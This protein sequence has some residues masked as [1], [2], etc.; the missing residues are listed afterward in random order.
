MSKTFSNSITIARVADGSSADS[1]I[2]ETS[3]DEILKFDTINEANEDVISFSPENF[4]IRVYNINNENPI[5]NFNWALYYLNG[6]QEYEFIAEKTNLNGFDEAI[7][8]E[9]VSNYNTLYIKCLQFYEVV[10]NNSN[11]S[12]LKS[13]IKDGNAFFKFIYIVN[14]KAEAIKYFSI[15]NGVSSDMA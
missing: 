3:Y 8:Y 10:E 6:N 9:P 7:S 5:L 2:I 11:F 12:Y 4:K 1:I 13:I 15:K 14:N